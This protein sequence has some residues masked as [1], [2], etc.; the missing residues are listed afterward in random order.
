MRVEASWTSMI[1]SS[2][3]KLQW[4]ETESL[5]PPAP[6]RD[7]VAARGPGDLFGE[8]RG[9]SPRRLRSR[10]V[11]SSPSSVARAPGFDVRV[12]LGDLGHILAQVPFDAAGH[13]V[14]LLER[15]IVVHFEMEVDVN[16]LLE[17][18]NGDI[19]NRH[20]IAV[21]DGPDPP[22]PRFALDLPRVGVN[23]HVRPGSDLPDLGLRGFGDG[24]SPLERKIAVDV[25]AHVHEEPGPGSPDP[26]PADAED[27][28]DRPRRR[29]SAAASPG[30][31]GR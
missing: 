2:R 25:E 29:R 6:Q 4:S 9:S 12:H 26:D 5:S 3:S 22:G 15:K 19:M 16:A 20:L 11:T 14:G 23:D 10:N 30:V 1:E 13:F 31:P 7:V 24:V 27:A 28:L 21:G 17:L 18:V 8:D